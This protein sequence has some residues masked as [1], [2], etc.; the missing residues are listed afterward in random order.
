MK[1]SQTN[2][3]YFGVA[4]IT[5]QFVFCF[6]YGFCIEVPSVVANIGSVVITCILTLCAIAG[7]LF[8][9]SGFSLYYSHLKFLI[10]SSLGFSLLMMALSME[11]YPLI[12]AFWAKAGIL[13]IPFSNDS[14]S[15]KQYKFYLSNRENR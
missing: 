1:P 7:T 5:L 10:W 6:V 9:Y 13:D 11:L 4:M 14:F 2:S 8:T 3:I 15:E 12:N